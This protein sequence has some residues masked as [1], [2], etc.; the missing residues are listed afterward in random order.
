MNLQVDIQ[1]A[2]NEPVPEEE[3]IRRWIRAALVDRREDTEITVRLVE[4]DE[5]AQ[6]NRTYRGK[7]GAT[8]VLSFPADLPA[9]L[10][11]PLL[12]DIVICAPLVSREAAA[13]Q[14]PDDAHWAHL[15]VHGTLHLLGYDHIEEEE[16]T[17][18]EARETK[19]LAAL[20]YPCP[21]SGN[22]SGNTTTEH[23]AQ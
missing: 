1:K 21:Y 14:K 2:T 20:N 4:H 23:L 9:D 17:I 12:G 7:T 13:Q 15:T 3:D 8:N 11:L 6:L 22:T 10:A 18:M 5:M 19:I 16:A